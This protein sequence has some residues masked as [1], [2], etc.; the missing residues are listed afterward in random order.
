[1]CCFLQEN[2][3][4]SHRRGREEYFAQIIKEVCTSES[5]YVIDPDFHFK[6]ESYERDDGRNIDFQS[7]Y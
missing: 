3:R 4:K 7:A 5:I 2:I 6:A 1:M